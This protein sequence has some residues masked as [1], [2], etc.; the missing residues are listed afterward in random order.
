[1]QYKGG[2]SFSGRLHYSADGAPAD[3]AITITDTK[4][5]R[6]GSDDTY[7]TMTR[8]ATL[9]F[10]DAVILPP[11]TDPAWTVK[12][13]K[14][15]MFAEWGLEG[16]LVS[17]VSNERSYEW[18]ID[19]GS[20][21]PCSGV[22][23]G[24]ASSTMAAHW[25]DSSFTGTTQDARNEFYNNGGWWYT[26]DINAYFTNHG[27][28][29][30]QRSYSSNTEITGQ[31]DRGNI[32]LLCLDMYYITYGNVSGKRVNKFYNTSGTGWGHFLLVKGYVQTSS[33]LYFE[34]YDPYSMGRK[35]PDGTP[36]GKD[37]YYDSNDILTSAGIW[38]PCMITIGGH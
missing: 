16:T 7:Y 38:W 3:Y 4:G 19:Q 37:R 35:Y 36:M 13:P 28:A 31:I 10:K 23:C 15:E 12:K 2:L 9:A 27:I 5:T 17:Y 30:S 18:Y 21:G 22:N 26:S 34:V 33:K 8:S 6:S 14:T 20:T 11:L 24:P 29:H 32:V 1:M 25:Y